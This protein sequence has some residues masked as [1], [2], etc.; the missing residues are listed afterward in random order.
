M[1]QLQV[2]IAF[3]LLASFVLL[4]HFAGIQANPNSFAVDVFTPYFY[5]LGA[6]GM[7]VAMS[8]IGYSIIH[9][10]DTVEKAHI[11]S[12]QIIRLQNEQLEFTVMKRTRAL[13][14]SNASLKEFAHAVSH[15]LKEP[16]RTISGFLSLASQQLQAENFKKE[17]IVTMLS[18]AAKRANDLD[19]L[20]NDV[21]EYSRLSYA[22]V[23][24]SSLNLNDVFTNIKERVSVSLAE[25]QTS[26][27]VASLP[28]IVGE[29]AL[30]TQLFQNILCNAVKYRSPERNPVIHVTAEMYNGFHEIRITDNGIGIPA[31]SLDAVFLPF[32]RLH[33]KSSKFDG[34]GIGLAM[35]K[36]IVA[37]HNGKIW[38]ESKEGVGTT[39]VVQLPISL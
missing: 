3:G 13:E 14:E 4:L 7:I 35:C 1:Q 34:N 19:S 32:K 39:I 20:I 21:L 10:M 12:E 36:K 26:L 15:D 24:M 33:G 17:E 5:L 23:K 25:T 18:F 29:K 16:L 2:L 37:L 6:L 22:D 28:E 8:A 27:S 11:K 31:K 38:A 9:Y 30:I